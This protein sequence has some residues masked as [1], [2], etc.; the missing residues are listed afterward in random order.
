M[1]AQLLQWR[2]PKVRVLGWPA[3][4]LPFNNYIIIKDGRE[5]TFRSIP[6]VVVTNRNPLVIAIAEH[7]RSRGFTISGLKRHAKLRGGPLR[8]AIQDIDL[9]IELRRLNG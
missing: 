7:V 2:Q 9:G 5:Y 6:E 1:T 8:A 3:F 4:H